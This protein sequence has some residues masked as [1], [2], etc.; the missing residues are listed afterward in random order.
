MDRLGSMSL[1]VTVAEAGSLSGAAKRLS[2]PLTTVSRKI[3]DLEHHLKNAVADA[4][5]P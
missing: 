1:L 5:E 3:A 2:T 4:L